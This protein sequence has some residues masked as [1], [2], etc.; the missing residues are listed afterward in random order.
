MERPLTRPRGSG[1]SSASERASVSSHGGAGGSDSTTDK[2]ESTGQDTNGGLNQST[3]ER[4]VTMGHLI[5]CLEFFGV[6]NV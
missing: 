2:D 5:S 1:K 3:F 4:L 6:E